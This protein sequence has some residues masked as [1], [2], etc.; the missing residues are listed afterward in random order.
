MKKLFVLS[1][2][3][4]LIGLSATAQNF[5][6]IDAESSLAFVIKNF[7]SKVNGSL[8]D[9]KG[10][11]V[12]DAQ[13]PANSSFDVSAD[14]NTINTNNGGRD[15]H[16]RKEDYFDVAKFPRLH[17]KSTKITKKQEGNYFVE[18]QITIKGVTKN[19]GFTFSAIIA[20]G[21]LTLQ[22]SFQLNRRDFGVGG[23]SLILSDNLTVNL[24][25]VAAA[26]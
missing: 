10:A 21:K 18:G 11:I 19:I 23:G 4:T 12:W 1:F 3:A 16:L 14:A 2:F 25:V 22:G 17:F 7:G 15:K 5:S 26:K 6:P 9:L 8:K 20:N 13:N 24:T